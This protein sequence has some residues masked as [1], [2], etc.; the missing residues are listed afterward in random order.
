LLLVGL[1]SV[2]VALLLHEDLEKRVL[3]QD[4][5]ERNEAEKRKKHFS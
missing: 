3:H 5:L 1:L 2:E 4:G